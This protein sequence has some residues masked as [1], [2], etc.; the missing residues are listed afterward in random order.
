MTMRRSTAALILATAAPAIA[1]LA[2]CGGSM[3]DE[4]DTEYSYASVCVDPNTGLR[5]TDN[6]C[7]QSYATGSWYY[8]SVGAVAPAIGA[9]AYGGS[10][11]PPVRNNRPAPVRVGGQPESGG[12]ITRYPIYKQAASENVR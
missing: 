9:T 1:V 2:A 4:V 12:L 5:V 3:S 10:Y 11:K 7:M 8:F 6:S